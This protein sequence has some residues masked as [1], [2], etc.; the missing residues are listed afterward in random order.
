MRIAFGLSRFE[1]EWLP[2]WLEPLAKAGWFQTV[3]FRVK[4][5]KE[6]LVYCCEGSGQELIAAKVYKSRQR[7]AMRYYGDYT[8]GRELLDSDGMPARSDRRYRNRRIPKEEQQRLE[9]ISWVQHEFQAQGLVYDAGARVP[10][11]LAVTENVILSSFVGDRRGSAPTLQSVT[12]A[13]LVAGEVFMKLMEQVALFLSQDR[14][15]GD[16]SAYNVLIW[17]EDFTVIDF[18]QAILA[19][20]HPEAFSFLYRDIERLCQYFKKFEVDA[21]PQMFAEEM[22]KWYE[23]GELG[24]LYRSLART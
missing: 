24:D 14:I 17:E 21:S 8:I 11:P 23:R 15:H 9:E 22:W 7:R 19:S 3:L 10:R 18:P 6:A 16:L 1:S 12:V 13:P 2:K 20:K 5:G 4:Q